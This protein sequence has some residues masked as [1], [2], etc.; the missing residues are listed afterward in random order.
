[1][2]LDVAMQPILTQMFYNAFE[3]GTSGIS[4]NNIIVGMVLFTRGTRIE[5]SKRLC[6]FLNLDS[7]ANYIRNHSEK[8]KL[9]HNF[10]L[11]FQ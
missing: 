9:T 8:L 11:F 2:S 4:L 10:C 6:E 5:K 1:M 3:G 7:R